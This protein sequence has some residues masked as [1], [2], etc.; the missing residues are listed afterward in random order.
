MAL[1]QVKTTGIADDAV[2]TDKLANAINTARD[3]NTA[4]VSLGADSV[5]GAKIADDAIDSEHITNG[6]IDHAHLANDCVDG[7][8]IADNSVGLA[9]MAGGTDGQ[10]ITYDASGDPV[11]VGPGTDGQVLTST[12]AGSPPAF[13]TINVPA[14]V[15]G[16]TG[17]DFNDSV[18]IRL[19]TD[20]D[21]ELYHDGS[22]VYLYNN[23]GFTHITGS[24]V[25]INSPGGEKMIEAVADGAVYLKHNDSTKLETS[26]AGVS[27]TG[28]VTVP[29]GNGID[30]AAQ[31]ASS[32]TGA[33]TTS[34]LLDGYEEGTFTLTLNNAPSGAAIGSNT[35]H[36]TRVGRMVHIVTNFSISGNASSTN[37]IQMAGIPFAVGNGVHTCAVRGYGFG[38]HDSRP[39]VGIVNGSV[40]E[41]GQAANAVAWPMMQYSHLNST[42]AG[43]VTFQVSFVYHI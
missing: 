3:A 33:S 6:S 8:N 7:D 42:T 28:N 18:K 16:S 21:A 24:Y 22:H 40:M 34:E 13:E 35:G 11:A 39:W 25:R 31:T 14:G 20:N 19:G 2:T 41:F 43:W 36:Y 17:V 23:T 29:A 26:A 1:T 5:T 38:F 12:G 4:K 9:H 32:A 27:V 37:A 10:I 15:G 30:F